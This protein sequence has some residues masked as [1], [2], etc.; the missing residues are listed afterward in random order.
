MRA[1]LNPGKMADLWA[2]GSC[3]QIIG[4][5][6]VL[7]VRVALPLK[8]QVHSSGLHFKEYRESR[9]H[10]YQSSSNLSHQILL[11]YN[12]FHTKTAWPIIA[13]DR[14]CSPTRSGDPSL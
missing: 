9:N 7:G 8:E 14:S 11:N 12:S 6:P 3:V 1:C 10:V 2:H 5:L 13:D 4:Q